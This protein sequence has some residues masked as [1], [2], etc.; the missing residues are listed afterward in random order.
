[1]TRRR[2]AYPVAA[3][4]TGNDPGVQMEGYS[5]SEPT[6]A[7]ISRSTGTEMPPESA[8]SACAL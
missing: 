5:I 1:M 7:E 8:V 4:T 2:V 3:H 6:P